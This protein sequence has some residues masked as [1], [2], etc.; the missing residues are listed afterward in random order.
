MDPTEPATFE[1]FWPYYVSQHLNRTNR[2]LHFVG[3]GIGLAHAAVSPLFP[4]ALLLAPIYGYG[5]AWIGHFLF[6]KNRPA[7]WFSA[8]HFAWSFR[9]DMRMFRLMAR[10][11]MDEQVQQVQQATG[12]DE[13][14]SLP[15]GAAAARGD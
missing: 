1:E 6:E 2:R 3:T 11:R 12:A 14:G 10:G 15:D 8:K 4:P 9:G 5:M 13:R 7:S